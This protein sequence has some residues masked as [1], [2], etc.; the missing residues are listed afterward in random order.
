MTRIPCDALTASIVHCNKTRGDRR[1]PRPSPSM[2]SA[3]AFGQFD[4]HF[5]HFQV[6]L[7]LHRYLD[8]IRVDGHVLGN[9]RHQLALQVGQVGGARGAAIALVCEDQL[10]AFL[11]HGGRLLLL[12]EEKVEESHGAHLPPNSRLKKPGFSASTKRSGLSWPRKRSIT[13]L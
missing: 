6:V 8:V 7:A 5:Q 4:L 2:P 1:A 3:V 13:S 9:H 11:G 10:K 12:A